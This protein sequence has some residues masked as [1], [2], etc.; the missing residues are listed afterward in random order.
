MKI[1][2]NTEVKICELTLFTLI[3]IKEELISLIHFIIIIV[4]NS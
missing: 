2:L 4:M 1:E 3:E